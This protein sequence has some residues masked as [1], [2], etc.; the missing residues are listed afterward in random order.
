MLILSSYVERIKMFF[1]IVILNML[2]E[3]LKL[4]NCHKTEINIF[5]K[6]TKKKSKTDKLKHR[7]Y[8]I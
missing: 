2:R 5:F 8:I 4:K 1:N 3:I 7:E 6:Q